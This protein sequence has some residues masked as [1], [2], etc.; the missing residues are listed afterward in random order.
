MAEGVIQIEEVG[1]KR[2]WKVL[3]ALGGKETGKGQTALS[4]HAGQPLDKPRGRRISIYRIH[5]GLRLKS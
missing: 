3:E 5:F 4:S 1:I 2:V